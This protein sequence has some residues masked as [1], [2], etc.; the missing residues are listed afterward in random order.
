LVARLLTLAAALVIAGCGDSP[1]PGARAEATPV[2][3]PPAVVPAAVPVTAAVVP[4]AV[5]ETPAATEPRLPSAALLAGNQAEA[6]E[7]VLQAGL[8]PPTPP[9]PRAPTTRPSASTLTIEPARLNLGSVA[10]GKFASGVVRLV[11]TGD[12]P[13]KLTQCK[14]SCGC[15]SANCPTGE[16]LEP[17]SSSEVEIRV[18]AG[19]R[20]R[21]INKTVTFLVEGQTPVTL[22]VSVDVIAYVSIQPQTIDPEVQADGKLSLKAT[23]DQPFRVISMSPALVDDISEDEAVEHE[24]FINWDT[25]R[26]LGQHRRV[27]VKIDHPEVEELSFLIRARP[28]VVDPGALQQRRDKLRQSGVVDASLAAPAQDKRLAVAIREGD[29][30]VISEAIGTGLDQASR[31]ALLGSA[32]RYGHVEIMELLLASG[33][34]AA[35]KD[36]LGRTAVL[37]AVQ[38]RNTEAVTV[39]LASGAD[40]NARDL[41]EG[42]ALLRAAGSFGNAQIVEALIEAGADVNA[43]DKNG[44]T[45]LMWAARWGDSSR[46]SALIAAGANAN[47]RDSNGMTALDYARNRRGDGTEELVAIIEPHVNSDAKQ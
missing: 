6:N 20:A 10:T 30:K 27:V 16:L 7:A 40:V 37:A 2:A 42:T 22:P 46:V 4:A 33:A 11:N 44:Q 1:S 26:E 19:A 45:A 25:W 39:L 34:N 17:G 35:T 38:S 21:Q 29:V 24:L 36:R 41:Q 23:D 28:K 3:G 13:I 12:E 9:T 15:T 5:E 14:T 32:S 47:N 31:D 18:T 8:T 43:A